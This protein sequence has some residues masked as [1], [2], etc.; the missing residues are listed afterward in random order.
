MGTA[1][2]LLI[3]ITL[4]ASVL[5]STGAVAAD[6]QSKLAELNEREKNM[7]EKLE[8]LRQRER[9]LEDKLQQIRRRKQ[10]LLGKPV[11]KPGAPADT[12]TAGQ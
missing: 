4:W 1:R 6:T 8:G 11:V 12:P 2:R 5:L 7:I 10:A 3:P 9:A